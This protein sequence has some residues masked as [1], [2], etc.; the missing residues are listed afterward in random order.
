MK[1]LCHVSVGWHPVEAFQ[2]S[3]PA[4]AGMTILLCLFALSSSAAECVDS[5][6]FRKTHPTQ[7]TLHAVVLESTNSALS[8]IS[9]P[10]Y[11]EDLDKP[12]E[13][14]K[15]D[16]S[17]NHLKELYYLHGF[18]Q[19]EVNGCYQIYSDIAKKLDFVIEIK[20]N[21]RAHIRKIMFRGLQN[22][23]PAEIEAVMQSQRRTA[24]GRFLITMGYGGLQIDE[25]KARI[26]EFYQS[27]GF[28]DARIKSVRVRPSDDLDFCD[29]EFDIEE[30]NRYRVGSIEPIASG[31]P[32]SLKSGDVF[33]L[34][35][36][37]DE[38]DKWLIP[39][40]NIGF[41]Y[42]KAV[43]ELMLHNDVMS[44]RYHVEN[45][46]RVIVRSILVRGNDYS[47]DKTISRDFTDQVGKP[48]NYTELEVRRRRLLEKGAFS[49]A[50]IAL[51]PSDV[52][53]LDDLVVRVTEKFPMRFSIAPYYLSGEGF[54]VSAYV[55]HQNLFGR[56]VY[57]LA[58][59]QIS[60]LRQNFEL[61]FYDPH[62][63]DLNFSWLTE[64]HD[65][66]L[67]Y[68]SFSS[69]SLGGGARLGFRLDDHLS[70]VS[71]ATF[72][73]VTADTK[74][75]P[76]FILPYAVV[77]LRSPRGAFYVGGSVEPL[78]IS[79][80]TNQLLALDA[81]VAYAGPATFS[82]LGFSEFSLGARWGFSI[83]SLVLR[84][85][86]GGAWLFP[87]A[88]QKIAISDRYFL[89]GQENLRGYQIV[90]VGPAVVGDVNTPFVQ[91]GGVKKLLGT[92]EFEFP[93]MKFLEMRGY[94]FSDMGNAW[95]ENQYLFEGGIAASLGFGFTANVWR[96]PFKCEIAF[97]L[98]NIYGA[99]LFDVYL[100]LTTINL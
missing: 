98:V 29:V 9:L 64:V 35:K 1:N 62:V 75:D 68:S 97:P 36:L 69:N 44:I 56:G 82:E 86:L 20:L 18:F 39:I 96:F 87:I 15:L 26:I 57:G 65:R 70:L 3:M 81:R 89:G 28:L 85:K 55:F 21:D 40:K 46:P 43:P 92:V 58:Q 30:G 94:L 11:D 5:Q 7:W 79:L 80:D 61:A 71:G 31:S 83:S 60:A 73:E 76:E 67:E 17:I 72:E 78:P 25:D 38:V 33:D 8:K 24:L 51:E 99:L 50:K 13:F 48:Y 95:S 2:V 34:P 22:F 47:K 41:P 14:Q 49:D 42:A 10:L 77:P 84:G 93:I 52:A 54:I 45:G 59:T 23:T 53:G 4:Y 6:T 12:V 100:G 19:A 16:E 90:S 66:K 74:V 32:S 37:T 91:I 27:Q 88:D 63:A